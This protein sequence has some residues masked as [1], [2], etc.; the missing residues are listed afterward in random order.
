[1]IVLQY[2]KYLFLGG[3]NG[4]CGEDDLGFH[5]TSEIYNPDSNTWENAADLEEGISGAKMASLGGKLTLIGG[6][7]RQGNSRNYNRKF[8]Q[9][10]DKNDTWNALPDVKLSIGRESPVVFPVPRTYFNYCLE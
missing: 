5:K 9:Y 1:M 6:F 4:K 3:C 10:N 2:E 8:Y 7:S